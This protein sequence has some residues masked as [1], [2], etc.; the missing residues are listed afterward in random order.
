MRDPTY[1]LLEIVGTSANSS[2]DA[3]RNALA[4][5]QASGSKVEWF[6]VVQTRGQVRTDQRLVFQVTL[7]LGLRLIQTQTSGTSPS[8]HPKTA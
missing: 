2:D 6:E 7:K 4:S 3:I 1:Q 5:V 8:P